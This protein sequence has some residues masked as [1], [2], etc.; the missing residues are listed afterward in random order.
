MTS[1]DWEKILNQ[2]N[3]LSLDSLYYIPFTLVAMFHCMGYNRI[4][5][6]LKA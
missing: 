4:Q 2:H 6:K 1:K 5:K 3:S